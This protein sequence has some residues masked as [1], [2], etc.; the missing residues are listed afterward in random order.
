MGIKSIGGGQR[1]RRVLDKWE[2]IASTQP[3][4]KEREPSSLKH[5]ITIISTLF[6]YFNLNVFYNEITRRFNDDWRL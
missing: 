6:N 3:P 1:G 4:L 2:W 5:D